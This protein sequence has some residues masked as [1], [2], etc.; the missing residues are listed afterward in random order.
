MKI[1]GVLNYRGECIYW[2][3]KPF[4]VWVMSIECK[5][6]D[7]GDGVGVKHEKSLRGIL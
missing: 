5:K 1:Q 4:V 6:F 2:I 7:L 3:V